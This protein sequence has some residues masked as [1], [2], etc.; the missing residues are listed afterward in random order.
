[1]KSDKKDSNK[2]KGRMAALKDLK[3]MASKMMGDD[4]SEMKKVTVAS[5]S[6]AGLKAGLNK[7]KEMMG[8]KGA[9]TDKDVERKRNKKDEDEE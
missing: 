2:K 7:A 9:L 4:L 6:K 8:E 5:P 1:M 3:E